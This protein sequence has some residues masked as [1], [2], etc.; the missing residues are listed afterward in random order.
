MHIFCI[1]QYLIVFSFSGGYFT[2]KTAK[3][4]PK[5]HKVTSL[6]NT[7][8]KQKTVKNLFKKGSNYSD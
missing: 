3:K 4:A 5:I 7:E 2:T 6:K 1:S 8:I